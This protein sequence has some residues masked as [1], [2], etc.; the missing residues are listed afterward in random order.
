MSETYQGI[1]YSYWTEQQNVSVHLF[2]MLFLAKC[3]S[4]IWQRS[5]ASWGYEHT[6]QYKL[7]SGHWRSSSPIIF[8]YVTK[9][10]PLPQHSCLSTWEKRKLLFTSSGPSSAWL[11]TINQKGKMT[12][13]SDFPVNANHWGEPRIS[14]GFLI[15]TSKEHVFNYSNTI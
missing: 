11:W 14:I 4:G 15:S 2:E 6:H 1:L 3:S 5:L 13:Q 12:N 9:M 7:N 8:R 10:S